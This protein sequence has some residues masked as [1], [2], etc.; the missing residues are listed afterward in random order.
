MHNQKG[1]TIPELTIT[2]GI[3]AILLSLTVFDLFRTQRSTSLATTVDQ[4]VSDMKSQQIKA[5]AGATQGRSA[6]DSYGIYFQ[7]N[8]YVLFHGTT[9]SSSD[10]S[11]A[12]IALSQNLTFSNIA[13]PASSLIFTQRSGEM[14]NYTGSNNTV[15]IKETTSNQQKTIT[16]NKYGVVSSIN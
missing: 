12:T 10:T 14:A 13:F 8:S 2:I 6:A 9:Y 4:V 11:N 3:A 5:M 16:V 7:T 1:F 15:T